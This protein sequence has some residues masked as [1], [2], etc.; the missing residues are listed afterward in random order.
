MWC[1]SAS[2]HVP[3]SFKIEVCSQFCPQFRGMKRCIFALHDFW[4]AQLKN[5]S[6]PLNTPPILLLHFLVSATFVRVRRVFRRARGCRVSLS[7]LSTSNLL[8]LLRY[9][10]FL[11]FLVFSILWVFVFVALFVVVFA[12]YAKPPCHS[13]SRCWVM[14]AIFSSSNG[15][16]G[17]GYILNMS[18]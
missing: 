10:F 15:C 8:H 12:H 2:F 9:A 11:F 3:L 16:I 7:L 4:V 6:F 14:N 18:P 17:I 5:T 13:V 1:F